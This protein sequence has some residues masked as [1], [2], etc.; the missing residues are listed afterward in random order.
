MDFTN[1]PLP[2]IFYSKGQQ[3]YQGTY[4]TQ[5][6]APLGS[7][8]SPGPA[9]DPKGRFHAGYTLYIFKIL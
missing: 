7:K 4:G 1:P 9:M 8:I 2:L 5:K 6:P 3:I